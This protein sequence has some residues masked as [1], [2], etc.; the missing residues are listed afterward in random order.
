ML[1]RVAGLFLLLP[2]MASAITVEVVRLY[3]P[4]SLHDTDGVGDEEDGEDPIQAAVLSRPMAISGA[5]P[6]D[7][8]KAVAMPHKILS[9]TPAYA[10][11]EVNLLIL[12]KVA[13]SAEMKGEKLLVR[14]DV[15]NLEI[16]GD[17][18]LTGRQ[19]VRLAIKA[20]R[21]TLMDYFKHAKGED[22]IEVSVGVIGTDEGNAALKD[23]AVR[24][25][26]GE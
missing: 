26:A 10:V 17:L 2:A 21:Q 13:L 7:L 15:Q 23:L 12:C 1:S 19:V 6:E 16:P 4:V 14:L 25:K 18:D 22:P 9:N 11:E 8:V 20:V 5:M 3:Q 24:F